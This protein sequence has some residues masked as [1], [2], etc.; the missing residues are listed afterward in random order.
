M[1]PFLELPIVL[2]NNEKESKEVI[3]KIQ[4]SEIE[5]YYPGFHDGVILVM[6][7][8]SSFMTTLTEEELSA[9][10]D[11]YYKFIL[12]HRGKF[13]NLQITKN[14]KSILHVAN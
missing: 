12:N 4:P 9:G 13:G 3:G 14:S 8:G 1:N 5:Y 2:M 7:S 6:K 11:A 10:L